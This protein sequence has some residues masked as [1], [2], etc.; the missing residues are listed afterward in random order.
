MT[1]VI[2]ITDEAIDAAAETAAAEREAD[3]AGALV[4]FAGHCRSEGGRLVALEIEHYP[5]MAEA[6]IAGVADEAAVRWPLTLVRIAH[7]HGRVAA[8]ETIVVVV[9]ASLHRAEAFA[10]AVF[11]MDYLKSRAPFWKKEHRAD[12]SVGDWVAPRQ[13]DVDALERWSP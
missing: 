7:R 12:G 2:R 10:A 6:E 1:P 5:G 8:G 4:V 3:D 11:L 13:A 9:T